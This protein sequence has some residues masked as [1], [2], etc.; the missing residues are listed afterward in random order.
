ME[1]FNVQEYF[2]WDNRL[3]AYYPHPRVNT[4]SSA[5]F[6]TEYNNL[7]KRGCCVVLPDEHANFDSKEYLAYKISNTLLCFILKLPK[8]QYL[9]KGAENLI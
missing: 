2:N 1:N 4:R 3:D 9:I 8:P 6:F 5:D 7:L